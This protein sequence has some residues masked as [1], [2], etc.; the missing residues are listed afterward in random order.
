MFRGHHPARVD[1]KGR[2]KL[3]SEFKRTCE[4]KGYGPAFFI[5]CLHGKRA[6]IFPMSEW[7]RLRR[8]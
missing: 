6:E 8:R 5:T 4:E 1:E 3:P 7:K 2:L